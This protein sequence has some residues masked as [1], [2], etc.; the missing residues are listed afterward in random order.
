MIYRR[1]CRYTTAS[2]NGQYGRILIFRISY[3]YFLCIVLVSLKSITFFFF[4]STRSVG[5]IVFAR[6]PSNVKHTRARE[7]TTHTRTYIFGDS[8]V[9]DQPTVSRFV[10][11][12]V[13]ATSSKAMR[14]NVCRGKK[15]K[16]R[17]K[18]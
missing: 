4:F 7:L 13:R 16:T 3:D 14:A 11:G 5:T 18:K 15:P 8:F 10:D 9:R 12:C 6:A 17:V 1:R 2:V